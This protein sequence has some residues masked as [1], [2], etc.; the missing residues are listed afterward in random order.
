MCPAAPL[1]L[2]TYLISLVSSGIYKARDR[3]SPT[4]PL[5][6]DRKLSQRFI[7]GLTTYFLFVRRRS[8]ALFSI[9][10]TA[11][12]LDSSGIRSSRLESKPG[13]RYPPPSSPRS[14]FYGCSVI[15]LTRGSRLASFVECNFGNR[16]ASI[17]LIF[18]AVAADRGQD[19]R[20]RI[21]A[22]NYSLRR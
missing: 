1:R 3:Y 2:Y 13:N 5:N 11:R 6:P 10:S 12:R 21:A 20:R 14:K 22:S 19:A 9:E 8:A 4:N 17:E 7:G 16:F 18:L 15:R